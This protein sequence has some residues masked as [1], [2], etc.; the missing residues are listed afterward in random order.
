MSYSKRGRHNPFD[1]YM[2]GLCLW[3]S[4]R[5]ILVI[6][7][8]CNHYE[9]IIEDAIDK[10][11]FLDFKEQIDHEASIKKQKYL[12]EKYEKIPGDTLID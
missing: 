5:Q 11:A 4:P 9:H 10:E 6:E 2:N 7:K 12:G 8:I 1:S 3:M